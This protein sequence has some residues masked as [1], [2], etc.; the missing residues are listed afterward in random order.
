MTWFSLRGLFRGAVILT[1]AAILGPCAARAQSNFPSRPIRIVTPFAAG[2][3]SDISLRVVADRLAARLGAGVIVD[4]N[5]GAG[6]IAAARAVISS[7]PDGYTL[8]LLS[9]ATAVSVGLF[10]TLTFDPRLDFVPV[11]GISD[12]AYI[13]V[14]NAAS[15]YRGLPD[16]IAAMRAR[17]GQLN[18]G[19]ANAGTSNHLTALLFKSTL[20]LDFVVVPYRGPSELM[21][22]LYRNDL[23]LVVNAYG[24]LR[25]A[26]EEGKMRVL[27]VSSATRSPLL[28]DVPT[29]QE[30]GVKDFEVSSW[31]GLYAPAGTPPEVV[32]RLGREVAQILAD[33]DVQKRFLDLGLEVRPS[34]PQ[35][36]D[37]R[38]RGEIERWT[39]VIED[40][41]IEKR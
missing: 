10:K 25:P 27:A 16:V 3:V 33:P 39:K 7:P 5:P 12:F 21:V 35:E 11:V 13:F 24:G 30:A 37:R 29:V 15:S 28:P 9:N 23:D 1:A 26:I 4:N 20:G 34:P 22:A 6:G 31:N 19:T 14:T 40:A 18:V 2:A 36:L 38:M 32:D 8:A 17:P 41:G